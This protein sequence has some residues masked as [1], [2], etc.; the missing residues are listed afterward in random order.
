M[1]KKRLAGI[2]ILLLAGGGCALTYRTDPQFQSWLNQAESRCIPRYSALP[3]QTDEQRNQF[4]SMTYQAYHRN[5]PREAYA[6]RLKI[7]Y[8]SN[9]LTV[10]CLASAMPQQ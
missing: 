10:D 5:L 9:G 3:I 4:L 2:G 7:L 1:L 6:D 8:P